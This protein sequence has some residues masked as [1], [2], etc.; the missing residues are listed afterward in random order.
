[1]KPRVSIE[2]TIPSYL[3]AR[4]SRDL[5]LAAHQ[6]TTREWWAKRGE[7]DLFVSQLVI[8]ECRAGDFQAAAARLLTLVDLPVLEPGAAIDHLVETLLRK[9]PLPS[10]AAYDAAHIAYAAVHQL[11]YLLTWNCR[12]IANAHFRRRIEAICLD[13][14]HQPPLIATPLE[15]LGME[16]SD[17]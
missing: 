10:R 3:A 6:E 4:S 9:V 11:D 14:G 12:H 7:F 1:M 5:I 8:D 16:P 2:T 17:D 13:L 15:F